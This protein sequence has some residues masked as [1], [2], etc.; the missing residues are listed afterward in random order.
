[1]QNKTK[2]WTNDKI[3]YLRNNLLKG[4]KFL[5]KKFNVTEVAI[6]VVLKR[7]GI[8]KKTTM[9]EHNFY[10]QQ[11]LIT[12]LKNKGINVT[13]DLLLSFRRLD[14]IKCKKHQTDVSTVLY[15]ETS[16]NWLFW[17]FTNHT[18]VVNL[19]KQLSK[20][21]SNKLTKILD[22]K[23][24][25]YVDVIKF[26]GIQTL[27]IKNTNLGFLKDFLENFLSTTEFQK[28]TGVS[29]LSINTLIPKLSIDEYIFFGFNHYFHKSTVLKVREKLFIPK[30]FVSLD[31]VA[32]STH[33]SIGNI[34]GFVKKMP[35][36][37]IKIINRKI[38]VHN[39]IIEKIK[40][41]DFHVRV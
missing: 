15:D 25:S 3:Q 38:Y 10:T 7:N 5:A 1:M 23:S 13:K 18:S 11:D 30:D 24:R 2:F 8:K 22:S 36:S 34:R 40:K 26:K 32:K 9:S 6:N 33:Y 27:F 28:L 39:S 19:H 41:G 14:F 17:F 29:R 20:K 4:N 12:I 35:T 16:Y 21:A 31:F 37:L